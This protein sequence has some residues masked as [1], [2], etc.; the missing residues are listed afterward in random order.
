[1]THWTDAPFDLLL[2]MTVEREREGEGR[3]GE[4]R[5]K[6]GGEASELGGEGFGSEFLCLGVFVYL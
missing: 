5:E 1:M 6:K 2:L 3:G 4:R